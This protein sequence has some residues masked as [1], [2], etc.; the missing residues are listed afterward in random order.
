M[1]QKKQILEIYGGLTDTKLKKYGVDDP[2]KEDWQGVY[3][4]GVIRAFG[5]AYYEMPGNLLGETI[6]NLNKKEEAKYGK[7][8]PSRS[9]WK[10]VY[11]RGVITGL[12]TIYFDDDISPR[13]TEEIMASLHPE[14]SIVPF[15]DDAW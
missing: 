1:M 3:M 5:I 2:P 13:T 8:Y 14:M 12:E 15:R 4:C 6:Q 7:R 10:G 11:M 9:D